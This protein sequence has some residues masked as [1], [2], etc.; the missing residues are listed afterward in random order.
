[1]LPVRFCPSCSSMLF[2]L[3]ICLDSPATSSTPTF[4]TAPTGP[5][6]GTGSVLRLTTTRK[7][8]SYRALSHTC[9]AE[10]VQHRHTKFVV[11]QENA[12][13]TEITPV[14]GVFASLTAKNWPCR[15][16]LTE[17]SEE[18]FETPALVR[19]YCVDG[20]PNLQFGKIIELL[21]WWFRGPFEH[22]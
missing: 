20:G 16:N 2:L 17:K 6:T 9:R 12:A 4:S 14:S 13:A 7:F 18:K 19:K 22:L 10:I 5:S 21:N 8:L 15:E 11:R 3:L 1:M